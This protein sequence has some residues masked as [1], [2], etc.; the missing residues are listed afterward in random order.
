[1]DERKTVVS[2]CE[3]EKKQES[4]A[5]S[6]GQKKTQK[7]E[8]KKPWTFWLPVLGFKG[9]TTRSLVSVAREKPVSLHTLHFISEA[10]FGLAA[11]RT[12]ENNACCLSEAMKIVVDCF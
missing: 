7:P 6:Q 9:G 1:M 3:R 4:Q 11:L 10:N 2:H 8:G 5:G 12:I